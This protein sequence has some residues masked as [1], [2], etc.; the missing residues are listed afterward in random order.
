M[1]SLPRLLLRS[2][3][4]LSKFLHS[5]LSKIPDLR[6]EGTWPSL[7]PVP[8]P[9]PEAF[10]SSVSSN[11]R[12]RRLSLQVVVLD[13]LFLGKPAACPPSLRIGSRL[14]ARQWKMVLL[15]ESLA[16]DMN[17]VFCVTAQDMGRT[18]AKTEL[19]DAEIGALHRACNS[20]D[21][22]FGGYSVVISHGVWL[23]GVEY[24]WDLKHGCSDSKS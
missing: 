8:I 11:W 2:C 7:W 14:S 22:Q 10:R 3:G 12:K 17:S 18:A 21:S 5:M 20:L 15:L 4:T 23:V 9:Y 16:E 1:N 24:P 6:D 13:W 19:H